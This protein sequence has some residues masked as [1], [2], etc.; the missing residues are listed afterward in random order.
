MVNIIYDVTTL[1]NDYNTLSSAFDT[2]GSAA[3]VSAAL[4]TIINNLTTNDIDESGSTNL[5]FTNTRV[6]SAISSSI[7]TTDL[8]VS[9]NLSRTVS[10]I[11]QLTSIS[12]G[13]TINS[14]N[15]LI[16]T[17]QITLSALTADYFTVTNNKVSSGDLVF[18]Q[19]NGKSGSPQ[20]GLLV[21]TLSIY[22]V[23]NG[24]FNII[25][26]NNDTTTDCTGV[27]DIA[28]QIIKKI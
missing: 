23:S 7:S 26:R 1:Q 22:A 20:S 14:L 21:P 25:L 3:G 28:F 9:G 12:T 2:V 27:Y 10:T 11:T 17:V 5:Y 6:A 8:T 13:V 16:T 15:G 18:C 24:S 4:T 19:V